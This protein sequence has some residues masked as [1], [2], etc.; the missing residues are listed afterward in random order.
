MVNPFMW[1]NIQ[2]TS[3]GISMGV[4][5]SRWVLNLKMSVYALEGVLPWDEC[6]ILQPKVLT[7]EFHLLSHY[8]LG[9]NIVAYLTHNLVLLSVIGP[10]AF[11]LVIWKWIG[12]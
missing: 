11:S 1:F 3:L 8:F 10:K 2:H 5:T 4:Y 9:I 7:F 12:F 6:K